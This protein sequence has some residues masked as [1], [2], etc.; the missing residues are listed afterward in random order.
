MR[1]IY[2]FNVDIVDTFAVAMPA[3]ARILHVGEQRG[4]LCMWAELDNQSELEVRTFH[5][6]G[7]GNPF[8]GEEGTYIGTA[9]VGPYVWHVYE[10]ARR[11]RGA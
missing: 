6:R 4:F 11:A 7:T 2:K 9:Q 1:T 5:V 8:T 10:T 3:Y